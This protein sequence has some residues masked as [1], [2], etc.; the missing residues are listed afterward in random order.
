MT[1]KVFLVANNATWLGGGM[2][3]RESGTGKLISFGPV[4]Y[5]GRMYSLDQW[6]NPTTN[7]SDSHGG[8]LNVSFGWG[9]A[10]LKVKDDGVNHIFSASVDG[11]TYMQLFSQGRTSF[12]AGAANQVGLGYNAQCVGYAGTTVSMDVDY[13]RR[14]V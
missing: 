8:S 11:I 7:A 10:Y 12:L 4:F 9:A 3:L 13:F 5:S 2:V 6:T 1:A 14:T